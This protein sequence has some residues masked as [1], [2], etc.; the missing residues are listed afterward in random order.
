MN[1]FDDDSKSIHAQ[2]CQM[3][4]ELRSIMCIIKILLPEMCVNIV[5]LQVNMTKVISTM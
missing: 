4:S 3:V 1:C 5:E 2:S